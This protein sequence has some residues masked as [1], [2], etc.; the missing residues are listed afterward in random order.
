MKSNKALFCFLVAIFTSFAAG[1]NAR[2][3]TGDYKCKSNILAASTLPELVVQGT[4]VVSVKDFQL[5]HKPLVSTY[6]AE[7]GGVE[8]QFL[9]TS[10]SDGIEVERILQIPGEPVQSKKYKDICF[11]NSSFVATDLIGKNVNGGLLILEQNNNSEAIPN[12][13]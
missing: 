6:S 1:C 7:L 10:T 9:V 3:L 11:S 12:D 5:N 8:L 2:H 13:I 4:D